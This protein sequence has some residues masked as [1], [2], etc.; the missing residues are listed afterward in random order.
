MTMPVTTVQQQHSSELISAAERRKLLDKDSEDASLRHGVI[1]RMKGRGGG[2]TFRLL[3]QGCT[4]TNA[5]NY[6]TMK[7]VV[8]L[9][10]S[11]VL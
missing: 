6:V 1:H 3:E 4:P 8:F 7:D 11:E 2:S 10:G 5:L 9:Q